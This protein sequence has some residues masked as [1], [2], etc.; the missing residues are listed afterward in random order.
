M[1]VANKAP[2]KKQSTASH[3]GERK[4]TNT[5][6]R[7]RTSTKASSA[8]VSTASERR[9]SR[10]KAAAGKKSLEEMAAYRDHQAF[11][12]GI[13]LFVMGIVSVFIYLSVFGLAG[14]VGTVFGGLLFGVFGW[15]TW[16]L[17]LACI[18]CFVF[19][20]VNRGDRRVS[21]RILG[22]CGMVLM[23]LALT[24]LIMGKQI[25]TEYYT[26]NNVLH[27]GYTEC[28]YLTC[29]DV[30]KFGKLSGGLLGRGISTLFSKII[31]KAGAGVIQFSLLLFFAYVFYGVEMMG[32]I[33]RRN[34]YR[35]EMEEVFEKVRNEE[36]YE[37]PS[38]QVF[39]SNH[40]QT[41][42]ERV[43]SMEE[44]MGRKK[45]YVPKMQPI[46]LR[47]MNE[48]LDRMEKTMEKNLKTKPSDRLTRPEDVHFSTIDLD[49]EKKETKEKNRK[50]KPVK[51]A[52]NIEK[53]K[54]EVVLT[55][56]VK[57]EIKKVE[58]PKNPL[59]EVT[60]TEEKEKTETIE[61]PIY[62]NEM[63]EKFGKKK[64]VTKE[65][66]KVVPLRT[67]E[68][69]ELPVMPLFE[70]KE[71]AV[72]NT[73]VIKN[74]QVISVQTAENTD[75]TDVEA[76][77]TLVEQL[78]SDT[79]GIAGSENETDDYDS[80][81]SS[82]ELGSPAVERSEEDTF[83]SVED[84]L[85][86]VEDSD[87]DF[88]DFSEEEEETVFPK[89]ETM[90]PQ[91]PM[92]SFAHKEEV[93]DVTP[94]CQTAESPSQSVT[95]RPKQH[96]VVPA[97]G[98]GT[99]HSSERIGGRDYV[100][101]SDTFNA[102][103]DSKEKTEPIPY[104][105]PSVELLSAPKKV[106]QAVSDQE[107]RM[108]ALKLKETLKSF[109]VKV[110]LGPVTC[111]P[112]VTRYELIPAQGVRVNKITNLADDLKLSMA[113]TSLRI[114]APIPGKSAVGI[115]VPNAEAAPVF[116][117]ELLEG[118]DFKEAKSKL[119][120]AVGKD[121]SGELIMADIGKMPHLLIAG[122][123]G[124]G[125]SVCIN[126]LIKSILYK[127]DPNEV[128]M[129]MIDPKVVELSVYNG[130][131]HLYCPVVT[132]PKEAAAALNWVTREMDL[133]YEKF[134]EL[135]VRNI[136][137]YNKKIASIE[138]AE[139][140]GYQRMPYFVVIVDEF[141]DLMMVAS[142]GVEEAVCRLAQKARAAGIHLILATQRPSVNV[143]TGVIKANIPSRIA[144]AVSS[145][146]DSRTILD[147]GGAE[148]LLGKGDMLFL[149][150]G[151]PEPVRVQGAF[152]SDQEVSEVVDFLRS[153]NAAPEYDHD[154]TTITEVES[155]DDAPS[156]KETSNR[157]EYFAE[158]G[159]F[160]I[161]SQ[162]A[163]AGQLQR[164]FS[165]GFNRAGRIIDQLNREGVVGPAEGT[166]PRKVLMTAAEFEQL[167][168]GNEETDTFQ[169][170][171]DNEWDF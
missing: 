120:I 154:V 29:E 130:I 72:S 89:Q 169:D 115:E 95:E 163:A 137:G 127:A 156:A 12:T 66:E 166:K 138:G 170:D 167:L 102:L 162:R 132:D 33:R 85:A 149:P 165:I 24:D 144:F 56:E 2:Q 86:D 82:S 21:R 83:T 13:T 15:F 55:E 79:S 100:S 77:D 20:L 129:I 142:K 88:D 71:E 60:V 160:V 32:M 155:E 53:E 27:K 67:P 50:R 34:A 159:R 38:Y 8:K 80:A 118:Q 98:T 126:T 78:D 111:G 125:K 45:R 14:K 26:S 10:T 106:E 117:R 109:N 87:E 5:S 147:R 152:I 112:A 37:E 123:T 164:R 58:E 74:E 11:E 104:V 51:K 157:D 35:N 41:Q 61:I 124:S 131:P 54:E 36:E 47:E 101:S 57:E 31:G 135:G 110:E 133:R 3:A 143:I 93:T 158:A 145:A 46:D 69:A 68:E 39:H 19:A 116:F 105:Y 9:N 113:A 97:S 134:S 122:A 139:S 76:D 1:A 96:V 62:R 63:M 168:G 153:T 73:E 40:R 108:T 121:F 22:F 23:L 4:K 91:K 44:S 48:R 94:S 119:T 18:I 90:I 52:D 84:S 59:S 103:N 42:R 114:E 146:I 151:A 136:A 49:E 43:Y 141:A 25:I 128:K 161:E 81:E 107:L 6:A 16:I 65:P 171:D 75:A 17:P 30:L 64:S 148:K 28:M 150:Y 92:N 70:D 7:K 140:A 99:T